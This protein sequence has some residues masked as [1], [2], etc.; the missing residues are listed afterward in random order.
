MQAVPGADDLAGPAPEAPKAIGADRGPTRADVARRHAR[1][2]EAI[3]REDL[4]KRGIEALRAAGERMWEAGED[5]RLDP[6]EGFADP[7]PV[8]DAPGGAAIAAAGRDAGMQGATR[9]IGPRLRSCRILERHDPVVARNAEAEA[10]AIAAQAEPGDRR[11]DADDHGRDAFSFREEHRRARLG[12]RGAERVHPRRLRRPRRRLGGIPER[13]R[14]EGARPGA[15]DPLERRAPRPR[16]DAQAR[17]SGRS[18]RPGRPGAGRRAPRR[19]SAQAVRRR[20]IG[21]RLPRGRR[22]AV[23]GAELPLPDGPR[24]RRLQDGLQHPGGW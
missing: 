4:P 11:F 10:A 16:A 9:T 8:A 14:R 7:K 19:R 20:R 12:V 3:A 17:R 1:L 6:H 2:A 24:P 23:A 13:S 21:R 5:E 22:R 15:R 18:P